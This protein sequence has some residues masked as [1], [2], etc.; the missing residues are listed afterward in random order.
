M[1]K[2][3]RATFKSFVCPCQQQT[4]AGESGQ[5]RKHQPHLNLFHPAAHALYAVQTLGISEQP[6]EFANCAYFSKSRFLTP[7]VPTSG[8]SIIQSIC[9]AMIRP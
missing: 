8:F 1:P 4:S 2:L 5:V 3:P 6:Y 9:S 7:A